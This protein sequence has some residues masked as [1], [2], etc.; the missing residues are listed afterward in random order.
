MTS[1]R[2]A[3]RI[4][5]LP[6]REQKRL[7][8][9]RRFVVLA[10]FF[11]AAGAVV[12]AAGFT[13]LGARLET[14]NQRNNFLNDEIA[15]LEKEI[16]EIETLK[17]ERQQLLDRKK[18]V[19]KL[20]S[21]RGEIVH[22]LDQLIRQLPEGVTLTSVKQTD[23]HLDISGYAQSGARVSTLMRSLNDSAIFEQPTLNVIKSNTVNGGKLAVSEFE[24]KIKI[25]RST[26][27]AAADGKN[28]AAKQ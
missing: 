21:N 18:V 13:F 25:T 8:R 10:V 26:E 16:S 17:K 9:L 3:I 22:I 20:Q 4:N 6:H 1:S 11:C 12:V 19:E 2:T 5:L 14:Q 23:D 7:A 28:K 15:K 27:D 24:L